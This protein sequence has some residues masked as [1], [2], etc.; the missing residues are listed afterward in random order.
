MKFFKKLLFF[1]YLVI[2]LLSIGQIHVNAG[3]A[4]VPVTDSQTITGTWGTSP[5]KFN[6]IT[7]ELEVYAGTISSNP[8]GE[9]TSIGS[10]LIK[11]IKSIHFND[12]VF[13]P[14]DSSFLFFNWKQLTSITGEIRTENVTTMSH[15][16]SNCVNLKNLPLSSFN[17]SKVKNMQYMFDSCYS[18]NSIDTKTFDT[19]NVV[20]MRYMF[21]QCSKVSSLDLSNYDT[22]KVETMASMFE[23]CTNLIDLDI[24]SFNT[25]NVLNMSTMFSRTSL[26]K[27]DLT[28]FDF[29]KVTSM[30]GM[31][32]NCN[33]KSINLSG[34]NGQNVE[35]MSRMF[36][37]C[38]AADINLQGFTTSSKLTDMFGMFQLSG[39]KNSLDLSGFYFSPNLKIGSM[40]YQCLPKE[41]ILGE[42]SV[43]KNAN[44]SY[45]GWT[46]LPSIPTNYSVDNKFYTGR[47]IRVSPEI[48]RI[49]FDNSD[50]FQEEYDGNQAGTYVWEQKSTETQYVTAK[51]LDSDGNPIHDDVVKSGNI[52][53]SYSTDQLTI[54]GY[55]FKE[56]Q[57]DPTGVFT[58][59]SQT[60]TYIYTKNAKNPA[61][62]D[63]SDYTMYVGDPKPT[64]K[65]FK[66]TAKDKDGNAIDVTVNLDAI[67]FSKPGTH[68]VTL[69]ASDGQTKQV[70]LYIKE[71]SKAEPDTPKPTEPSTSSE[72]QLKGSEIVVIPSVTNENQLPTTTDRS[73]SNT[74]N[75]ATPTDTGA[76]KHYPATGEKQNRGWLIAGIILVLGI[77][78]YY[79]WDRTKKKN[80]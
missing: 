2:L 56:V 45:G 60:V 5:I 65:D 51:Y 26:S 17:T 76:T 36:E 21:Y 68:Q 59:Q 41:L 11:D 8:Q 35:N 39:N 74:N 61:T 64:V 48:P 14:S 28:F 73:E 23:F 72:N 31:F 43:F 4:N 71:K 18:L 6:S 75:V 52:G 7:G 66:A 78:G 20:N 10:I 77:L 27:I 19:S 63:G 24:S 50:I 53:D 42:N 15:M 58:D 62:I 25:S 44:I 34:S 13:A 54:D 40:F 55:T 38:S 16:F 46:Y 12:G 80:D 22:S 57:G 70:T 79:F 1:I 9:T 47:W 29:S 67:D 49:I 30:F 69:K 37:N 32:L 33:T 3:T